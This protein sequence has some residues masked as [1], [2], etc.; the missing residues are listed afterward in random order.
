MLSKSLVAQ[1]HVAKCESND[2]VF[3]HVFALDMGLPDKSEIEHIIQ[4][5][6]S[7]WQGACRIVI[8]DLDGNFLDHIGGNGPFLQDGSFNSSS[9]NHPQGIVY[10]KKLNALFVTDTENHAL[11]Q[12]T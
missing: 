6:C 5:S 12:V 4:Q 3:A 10:S 11:R 7:C 1:S 2:E 8:T 9:F